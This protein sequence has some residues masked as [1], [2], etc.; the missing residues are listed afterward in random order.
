MTRD[1]RGRIRSH[2]KHVRH[3][4]A[5]YDKTLGVG[6]R[7]GR[8]CPRDDRSI[9]GDI[10]VS[11]GSLFIGGNSLGEY[12]DGGSTT[13]ASYTGAEHRRDPNEPGHHRFNS[14]EG[15]PRGEN[16]RRSVQILAVTAAVVIGAAV[17]RWPNDLVA[18]GRDTRA[19]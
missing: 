15:L 1:A 19:T 8:R 2:L 3:W 7:M 13:S 16:M 18:N 12:F 14:G 11:T 17:P 6:A 5:T 10:Q 4:V 9:V